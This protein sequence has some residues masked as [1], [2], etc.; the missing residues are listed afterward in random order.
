MATAYYSRTLPVPVDVVWDTVAD[1]HGLAEWIERIVQIT[2]EGGDGPGVVGSV[3]RIT[4]ADGRVVG[5][6]LV[7]YDPNGR[8]YSYEFA[9][10]H[11]FPVRSYR[12][13]VRLL[14]IIED[15]TTFM[16]WFGEYDCD[17][18]DEQSCR[19]QFL[20]RYRAFCA[21]LARYLAS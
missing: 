2:P 14:P 7:A 18:A 19:D 16:E 21:D 20:D 6:R 17:A 13:T 8:T 9:S 11:P 15:D 1:F 4:L 3:R 12:A 5:E 10:E